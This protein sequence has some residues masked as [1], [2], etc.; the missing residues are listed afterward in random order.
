M[1]SVCEPDRFAKTLEPDAH[2]PARTRGPPP[3]ALYLCR[4]VGHVP[5]G[6]YCMRVTGPGQTEFRGIFV[7]K[8]LSGHW[9]PC[10]NDTDNGKIRRNPTNERFLFPDYE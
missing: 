3:Q 8:R 4:V 10:N 7:E 6:I 2:V 5:E 1:E 9:G